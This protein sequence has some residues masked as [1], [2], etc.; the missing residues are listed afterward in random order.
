LTQYLDPQNSGLRWVQ[1][2]INSMQVRVATSDGNP[3]THVSTVWAL[4]EYEPQA[5][6]A[7]TLSE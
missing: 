3:D 6:M 2:T 4:V 5:A 1:A 7:L